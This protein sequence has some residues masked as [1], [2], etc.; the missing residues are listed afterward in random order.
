MQVTRTDIRLVFLAIAFIVFFVGAIV[1][2]LPDKCVFR[3][4][5]ITDSGG[6]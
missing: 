3:S 6:R 2:A 1:K 4:N 5:V